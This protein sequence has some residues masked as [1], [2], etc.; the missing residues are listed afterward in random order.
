MGRFTA[1]DVHIAILIICE[2][3]W[4]SMKCASL[5]LFKGLS[6]S[7]LD[8]CRRLAITEEQ[9]YRKGDK[10]YTPNNSKK[11]LAVVLEG[12]V[13]VWQGRVPMNDL[14][15]GDVFGVAALFSTGEDYPS[16]VVAESAC[17]IL[18][19][20]QETVV[21]WMKEVPAVAQNYVGFLS[22][23]I[24]FLN[25]RL[26]TLTAGQADGKLWRYLLAHR[27]ENGVVTVTEGMS[28]LAERLD[29]GRSSLYRSLDSLTQIGK[30]RRERKKIII[31]KT[32]E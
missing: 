23:R 13:R 30:I 19:I 7:E 12:H 26:S 1:Y 6:E 31:L 25:R 24:R 20:P 28:E 27:D 17:R 29:M 21:R 10:I 16:T 2:E 15:V 22:D 18:Y 3:V 11:A 9:T 32:E 4:L 14:L 5:F 8:L